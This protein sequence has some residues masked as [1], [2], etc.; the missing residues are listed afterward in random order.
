[1]ATGLSLSKSSSE[2][3]EV[4][5]VEEEDDEDEA[6]ALRGNVL[7]IFLLLFVGSAVAKINNIE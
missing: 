6:A 5:E 4:A 3:E 7:A 2:E 1:L